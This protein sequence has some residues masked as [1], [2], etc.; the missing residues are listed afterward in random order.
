MLYIINIFF[1]VKKHKFNIFSKNLLIT[2][3]KNYICMYLLNI[4]LQQ[5]FRG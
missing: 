2:K 5:T 4:L 3:Y 1:N